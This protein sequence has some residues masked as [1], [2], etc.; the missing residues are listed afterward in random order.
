MSACDTHEI[1]YSK[2]ACRS[3]ML[4]LHYLQPNIKLLKP[5]LLNVIEGVLSN[6]N[7]CLL[8]CE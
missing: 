5:T 1:K 3:I 2:L 7:D 8:V 6:T 4:G